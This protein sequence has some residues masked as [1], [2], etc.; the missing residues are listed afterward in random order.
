MQCD[1]NHA[2]FT[3]QTFRKG[4]IFTFLLSPVPEG[5][6]SKKLLSVLIPGIVRRPEKEL[7]IEI[8]KEIFSGNLLAFFGKLRSNFHD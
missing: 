2:N 5:F 6:P 3:Y 8:Y 1:L 4:E 7:F